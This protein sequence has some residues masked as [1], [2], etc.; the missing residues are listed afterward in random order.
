MIRQNWRPPGEGEVELA[1][2]QLGER[3]AGQDASMAQPGYSGGGYA[4][5]GS[6]GGSAGGYSAGGY[7][8]GS[9]GGAGYAAG[10]YAT[11]G[12]APAPATA[13][14]GM[15][16]YAP[17]G[18]YDAGGAGGEAADPDAARLLAAGIGSNAY[19]PSYGRSGVGRCSECL[20]KN[21]KIIVFGWLAFAIVGIVVA[22][23]IALTASGGPSNPSPPPPPMPPTPP[24]PPAPPAPPTPPAPPPG[25]PSPPAPPGPPS[26]PPPP[27]SLYT[28]CSYNASSLPMD[29]RVAPRN[30]A[31]RL[32]LPDAAFTANGTQPNGAVSGSPAATKFGATATVTLAVT[33][34]TYCVMLQTGNLAISSITYT[35]TP[36]APPLPVPSPPS[37]NPSPPAT[38]PAPPSPP[39]QPP[40]PLS[41]NPPL[42]APAPPPGTPVAAPSG[43]RRSRALLQ[44]GGGGGGGNASCFCGACNPTVL[45]AWPLMMKVGD[46]GATDAV[47]LDFRQL[48][49]PLAAGGSL[50]LTFAYTGT[51]YGSDLGEGLWASDPWTADDAP[52]SPPSADVLLTT[53][54][55]GTLGARYLLPCLDEPKYK[56]TFDVAV[57]L[58]TGLTALSNAPGT[59]A[60]LVAPDNTTARS[61]VTF[62][63]T[64]LMSTY[65]LAVAAGKMTSVS[66]TVADNS[67][68]TTM[69]LAVWGP[70]SMS[71]DRR[72]RG[73]LDLAAASYSYFLSYFASALPLPKLDLLA[74]PGKTYSMENWGLLIFD[75]VRFACGASH[76][77]SAWDLFQAADVICHEMSHQWIGNLVS[78]VD[79][80]NMSV[81]EGFASYIE[82]D[83]VAALLPWIWAN[84]SVAG[85]AASPLPAYPPASPVGAQLRRYAQPPGGQATGAHEGPISQARWRDEMPTVGAP[86][87]GTARAPNSLDPIV[88][89]KTAS[90]LAAAGGL[91][92][93]DGLRAAFQAL[94][95]AR[96]YG[97]ASTAD[98][99]GLIADQAVTKGLSG[100]LG[101]KDAMVQGMLG[102]LTQPGIPLVTLADVTPSP[103]P[104]PSPSPSL[105]NPTPPSPEPAPPSPEP[106][107]PTPPS[108][109]PSP[110]TPP[111]SPPVPLPPPTSPPAP[112]SQP[113]PP[114]PDPSPPSQPSPPTSPSPPVSPPLGPSPPSPDPPS[115]A[116]PSPEPPSSSVARR[117]LQAPTTP[118]PPSPNPSPPPPDPS[119]PSPNP[120]SP[121]S[122]SLPSPDPSPPTPPSPPSPEPSP[123]TPPSPPTL[124][125]PPP[126]P[127]PPFV[128]KALS[129]TQSRMCGWGMW[130]ANATDPNA[131]PPALYCPGGVGDPSGVA[132]SWWLPVAVSALGNGTS[133]GSNDELA[134]LANT[135][136]TQTIS[137]SRL[138]VPPNQWATRRKDWTEMY[139][140]AYDAAHTAHLLNAITS[141]LGFVPPAPATTGPEAADAALLSRL[142]SVLDA[143]AVVRD[144]FMEGLATFTPAPLALLPPGTAGAAPG[145]AAPVPLVVAAIGAAMSGSLPY[146]GAGLHTLTQNGLMA[147]EYLQTLLSDASADPATPTCSADLQAWVLRRLAPLAAAIINN[148]I[149]A[150]SPTDAYLLRLAKGNVVTEAALW[151]DAASA[152]FLCG[153]GAGG[154]TRLNAS[155]PVDPDWLSAALIA[156]LALNCSAYG[157]G[158]DQDTA[159]STILA[160][161][162]AAA[163]PDALLARL[164]TVG[165][166][167]G[168][169]RRARVLAA[170]AA[171][172]GA[173]N[174][175]DPAFVRVMSVGASGRVLYR[176]FWSAEHEQ[177]L[178]SAAGRS[179]AAN[180]LLP[181]ATNATA[182]AAALGPLAS[183]MVVQLESA[184]GRSVTTPAALAALQK[185]VLT[186]AAA[187]SPP[188]PP[189]SPPGA[190]MPPA[191]N[192][193]SP[194]TPPPPSPSPPAPSPPAAAPSPLTKQQ[195]ALLGLALSRVTWLQNNK[196]AV[197]AF[198]AAERAAN[199]PPPPLAPPSPPAPPSPEPSPPAPPSPDPSPPSPTPPSPDPSP[200]SPDPSPP[201]PDPSPPSPDPAP[202]SPE[203]SPPSPPNQP[204]GAP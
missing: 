5:A 70:A 50:V 7:S 3:Q 153:L 193:T 28:I 66:Y 188:P 148:T 157:S 183:K 24:S 113:S 58:P 181:L 10:Q 175:S 89:S 134:V 35:Y 122:P 172:A 141:G 18:A 164:A 179:G 99:M 36:P 72:L 202:P 21:W 80:G 165:Y 68:N 2:V 60:P 147:L 26:P 197:C 67:T 192:A 32:S 131:A 98:L 93:T 123:P 203:P 20:G 133:D 126:S 108:P 187:A 151:G 198:L 23:P 102:W 86:M 13:A 91:I 53:Q 128:A 101:G 62:Q 64:P 57:E 27:E 54:L 105:P 38:P 167:A 77:G 177:F 8:A 142:G 82:Y 9:Y 156:P 140:T 83:C 121:S 76:A 170:L 12:D 143:K 109:D 63:T 11:Y 103:P 96:A 127:A 124:P 85:A 81:T 15:Q 149:A 201:S 155:A 185:Q 40:A 88:Y 186:V 182:A 139:M 100:V 144:A 117:L 42:P 115:P 132:S 45:C 204:A 184:A 169:A 161:I 94:V 120:S 163:D 47:V 159:L 116:P 73:S 160:D 48:L 199:T 30:Y 195:Q 125:S 19:K 158:P 75:P 78:P 52:G 61:L 33:A 168:A 189:P 43:S 106:S 136:A 71:P 191:P 29:P 176:L 49:P 119:P 41:P 196:A 107:P 146:T 92:G 95:G 135:T 39:A 114:S 4:G 104:P 166:V 79:W 34:D 46:A 1:E 97:T 174:A 55:A 138:P 111:V 171:G 74:V 59:A 56:A 31:L 84:G 180:E 200:P 51:I 129:A 194:A 6:Y 87:D 178:A 14:G 137:L 90:A 69:A 65:T 162:A 145:N 17:G 130:P 25:L 37:P 44:T 22:V 110:P 173:G 150:S 112:P 154:G 190:P 16:G 152:A 118:S